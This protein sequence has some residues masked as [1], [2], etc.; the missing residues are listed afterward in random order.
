ME[1]V[2]FTCSSQ[3]NSYAWERCFAPTLT[4][5]QPSDSSNLQIGVRDGH[6]LRRF[7]PLECER[8]QGFPDGYTMIPYKGGAPSDQLRYKA[9][10]NSMAVNSM[11]WLGERIREVEARVESSDLVL[12]DQGGSVINVNMDGTTGT[13]RREMH[14]H[15]PVIIC[16]DAEGCM[17]VRRVTPL[18]CERLQ[19]FPDG[20][21]NV[22]FRGKVA[23]DKPRYQSLGNSMAVNCMAWLGMRIQAVEDSSR[24]A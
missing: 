14:G 9:L 2:A 20:H 16:K 5:Q 18:E 12:M 6:S 13:L 7:T 21:T 11:A 4:A 19:G 15:E 24:T 1:P 22:P 3:A 8:L 23:S 17:A 10:G